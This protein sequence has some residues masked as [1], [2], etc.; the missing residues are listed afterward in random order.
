MQRHYASVKTQRRGQRVAQQPRVPRYRRV[1]V[2]LLI[3][4]API[5]GTL[6]FVSLSTS[7]QSAPAALVPHHGQ[8]VQL[9]ADSSPPGTHLGMPNWSKLAGWIGNPLRLVSSVSMPRVMGP[10]SSR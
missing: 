9:A 2:L 7:A 10:G 3:V 4:L 6:N 8:R 1:V 5:V